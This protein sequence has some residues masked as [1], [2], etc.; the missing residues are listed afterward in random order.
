MWEVSSLI[1]NED[2]LLTCSNYKCAI[3]Y[4]NILDDSAEWRFYGGDGS[5]ETR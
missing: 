3:I 4:S 5:E 2:G 1:F